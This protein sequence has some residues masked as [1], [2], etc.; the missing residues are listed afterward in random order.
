MKVRALSLLLA[1]FCV[2]GTALAQPKPGY[3]P[4]STHIFPAGGRRGTTV[5]V[6]VGT[7]CAPPLTNFWLYGEGVSAANVLGAEAPF[8]GEPAVRR[9]PTEIPITYPRQ[10]QSQITIAADAPLGT[11]CWRLSCAQGGTPSRPFVVGDLPEH[12]EA[13]SNSLPERAESISLPI[14]LNGQIHGDRDV[15]YFRFSAKQGEV[16][17]CE[18]MARR[19]GSQL[20]P[21]IEFQDSR[22]GSVEFAEAYAGNDPVLVFCAPENGEYLLRIA[23]VTF[24]GSPACVYR[25]NLTDKPIILQAFPPSGQAGT[26]QKIALHALVADGS[27]SMIEE[28]VTFPADAESLTV[29]SPLLSGSI[30]LAV[31][32]H[33]MVIDAEPN[34]SRAAAQHVSV[35]STIN[36]RFA[37]KHDEDWIAFDA[38]ADQTYTITCSAQPSHSDCLP[39]LELTDA[40]GKQ[41]ARARSV[42]AADRV[43]RIEWRAPADGTYFLRAADLRVGAAG[44]PDFIYRLVMQNAKPDFA[45]ELASDN[46]NLMPGGSAE[47]SVAAQR[48]GGFQ[49]PIELTLEGLPVGMEISGTTIAAGQTTGKIKLQVGDDVAARNYDLRLIGKAQVGDETLERIAA[50]FHLGQDSERASIGSPTVERLSLAVKHKPVFRL[51]CLEAYQYAHR[52]TIYPYL[53][54]IQRLDGFD[55]EIVLQRGDR[56]NRDLDGVD[57]VETSVPPGQT[58]SWLPIY[59]PETMHINVQ[60][61]SQ[62]YCQGSAIFTD[63]HGQLQSVLVLSE[64]R[65]MLRTLP[66]VVKLRTVDK[67]LTLRAGDE[68]TCRVELERTSNFLGPMRLELRDLA[69]DSGIEMEPVEIRAGETTATI[70]LRVGQRLNAPPRITVRGVGNLQGGDTLVVSEDTV[71][72]DV[73]S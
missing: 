60:S 3:D 72:L 69:D 73:G 24:H 43:C 70:K 38:V 56:Q 71:E 8:C 22:G 67:R 11:A 28:T 12:V 46:F 29:T 52:G 25:I 49:E 19:L 55:G 20:D 4:T 18:V 62:L 63:K 40:A 53:M 66:P 64:N 44:G 68:A 50:A 32:T 61:Q 37:E 6:R 47:L 27:M 26:E 21:V 57:Y 33:P 34:D 5:D 65:N 14:T 35:P 48:R 45:L 36:G 59:L 41:L 7:E 23:N 39:T 2:S 31:D 15:D 9:K 42:E 51:E 16:V 1:V 10:W 58:E 54:S 13:E 17:C 30:T